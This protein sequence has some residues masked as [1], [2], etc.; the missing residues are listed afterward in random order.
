M[1]PFASG[2]S[3]AAG[4]SGGG[5]GCFAWVK[6]KQSNRKSQVKN[7]ISFYFIDYQVLKLHLINNA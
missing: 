5:G 2:S 6:V 7:Q 3:E 1:S 4:G